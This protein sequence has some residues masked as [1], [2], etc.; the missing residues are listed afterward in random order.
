IWV[1]TGEG[2]QRNSVAWGDGIYKSTDGGAHFENVG[3]KDTY[4]IA[5]IR[6]HPTDPNIVYVAALGNIFG[7]VGSRGLYKTVDGGKTWTKLSGGLP[8]GPMAGADGLVMDPSNPE[9]LYVSFWD[10]IRYPWALVSGGNLHEEYDPLGLV[11]GTQNGGIYKTTDGGKTWQ[12]LTNGLP[13]GK[14]GRIALA[15]SPQHPHT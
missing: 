11:N 14:M 5:R 7:Q 15:I 13:N 8:T 4:N 1:G 9:T 6:L 3:L 10:R 12:R 2:H